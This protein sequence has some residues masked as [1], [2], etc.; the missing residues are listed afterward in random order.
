MRLHRLCDAVEILT[1][2]LT[3]LTL[4]EVRQKAGTSPLPDDLLRELQPRVEYPTFGKWKGMLEALL[5]HCLR[6]A[7]LVVPELHDLA[8]FLLQA[9]PGGDSSP[10][11]QCLITLRNRLVHGG[12]T[13]KA[14]ANR[15]LK[16]WEPWLRDEL[17]PRLAVL[18]EI[19]L[20]HLTAE[21]ARRLVGADAAEGP[22]RSMSAALALALRDSDGHV[23]LLRGDRWLDLWPLCGYGHA[24]QTSLIGT[25]T[26]SVPSPL[27]YVR[28]Q[29]DRLLY[30]A[31]GVELAQ[32]ERVDVIGTFRQ[33]F[34]LEA[35][36]ALPSDRLS[37]FEA[38]IQ[39][40]ADAF[41]GEQRKKEVTQV[42]DAIKG[43]A[44]GVLWI[45]GK[46]GIGKSFLMAKVA[47]DLGNAAHLWRIVWR[48]TAS[49][50]ARCSRI[51]FLRHAITKLAEKLGSGDIIAAQEP[52]ELKDQL[53]KLLADTTS[54]AL[55][56]TGQPPKLLFVL[57]GLD[58]IARIDPGFPNLLFQLAGANVVWLCAGRPEG[59]LSWV[60]APERCTHVFPGAEGL[61]RMRS[62]DVRGLLL[63]RTGSLK[64]D[65]LRLD[66]EKAGK[67][68]TEPDVVNAA[69]EAVV[70]K[71]EGLP[72]YVRFVVEDVLAGHFR[73]ADLETRLPKSLEAYYD[74]LLKRLSIG[75]LQALLTP[76]MVTITWAREP[77]SDDTLLALMVRRTVLTESD[78]PLLRD[79]LNAL[80]AM[81]RVAPVPGGGVGYEPYHP[82][83]REH[84][85][86]DGAGIIGPQ[87]SLARKGLIGLVRDWWELPA[88]HPARAYVLR[89]GPQTLTDE[90]RWDDLETLLLD[91]KWG[92]LFL[93][94]KAEAGLVFDLAM[95]FTRVLEH[96]PIDHGSRRHLRLLEQALRSD[97]HFLARHPT[98]LF[99]CLWNRCWWFDCPEA[100]AH[101]DPPAGGWPADGPP[102]SRPAPE[103]LSTLLEGWREAKERSSPGV[104][105]LRSLHPPE[106]ALGSPQLACLRVHARGV[107]SVAFSPDGHRI[108][109][110]SA[111]WAVRVWDAASG[112][113]LACLRGHKRS[114][115]SVTYSPDGRRIVSGSHDDTVWVWDAASGECI[116]VMEG[117]GDIAAIAA[118]GIVFR[119]RA[120]NRSLET[121]IE[122]A[123]SG[124]VVAWF[125]AA[126]DHITTHPSGRIWAGSVSNHLYIIRLEGAD[127]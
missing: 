47:A 27:V 94:A 48:F 17:V 65:L 46:G 81:L 20:C 3:V 92:L 72:L 52:N 79:G 111:D 77:L 75:A 60:F 19:D 14:E 73:F 33:L 90:E 93:E 10:P 74:D 124:E 18:G 120:M 44:S 82:T 110:G 51:A 49:D 106:L 126:M 66:Q 70:Q 32:G 78:R 15:F 68:P 117:S 35:R 30:A 24:T 116:E 9:L 125:P 123:G 11:E 41:V 109:S 4:G 22:E 5:R 50:L 37:D 89:Q 40:D 16:I 104:V 1:R 115:T 34:Q 85:R 100:A 108:V 54:H 97:L 43:T 64:Y 39:A 113:E 63:D 6:T 23:V 118:A 98:T 114:V 58:E 7:S 127:E 62:D 119:W 101:Y 103:R 99:Q 61:P 86:E 2:F 38:E 67:G 95:D 96:I 87:N 71:A 45:T 53:T 76:L 91:P 12:G 28:A 8:G 102:W 121:V 83:F 42:K 25:R 105:W 112:V 29:A 36:Q 59:T 107:T 31:L 57:D 88:D 84:V 80:G 55:P 26:A 21:T 69:I 13:T 122:P 56:R